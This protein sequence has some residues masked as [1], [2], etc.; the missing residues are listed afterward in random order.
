MII[1]QNDKC[2]QGSN[3]S[4]S[5]QCRRA[6]LCAEVKLYCAAARKSEQAERFCGYPK[7]FFDFLIFLFSA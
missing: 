3:R 4:G 2:C 6:L 5:A 7:I 1:A